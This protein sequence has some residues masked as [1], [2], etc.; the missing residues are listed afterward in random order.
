MTEHSTA[1][2]QASLLGGIPA[3]N[4][5]LFRKVLL[6]AG[7]PA[8]WI[9][10][11]AGETTLLIRDIEMQRA[12]AASGADK[13]CCPADFPPAGGLSAD[14]AT[15]TAQ[16]AAECLR[17]RGVSSVRVDRSLPYIYA[18]FL[19]Q[20]GIQI[21]YDEQWGV[22][23][24][25]IKSEQEI[26]WL[27]EAQAITER[28]ME[29]ACGLIAK[30]QA[31][32]QGILEV[33]GEVLTSQRVKAHISRF[34]LDL[35][36]TTSHGSIV[37]TAPESADCHDSGKG[38]LRTG[39]PVIV[40]IF[41]RCEQTR[42]HGDCTRTVVHGQPSDLVRRM[43]AAVCEAKAAGIAQLLPGNRAEQVHQA[44]IAVQ[45][46]HGF[47][48]SRGQVSDQP[49]IQH[50]TGHGIGLEVHEPILLDDGGG[51]MLAGEVFTVEP[52]LYGRHDGGVR[53]E[54]MVVVTPA[55]PRNL[56][57]LHEGLDWS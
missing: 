13:V 56:N 46:K 54:D 43:H 50:G 12:A 27:A 15:A 51:E 25:R 36:Y 44:V 53:V 38:P 26:A 20:V 41:P 16:A 17:Q 24:R 4:P 29:M 22:L 3:E 48:L 45:Q 11:R 57:R 18:H 52:G 14:R 33:D 30:A 1:P 2:H 37:A 40:D 35:N 31:N 47:P 19:G 7:D 9:E 49:S 23:D 42:Y 5:T 32:S 39:V 28:A 8:A 6:T 55:G 21:V 34:L 10:S